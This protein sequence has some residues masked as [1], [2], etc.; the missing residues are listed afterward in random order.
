LRDDDRS[1]LPPSICVA[2]NKSGNKVYLTGV[3][4]LK[5]QPQPK[6]TPAGSPAGVLRRIQD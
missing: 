3:Y 1:G 2:F 5:T 6:K 4:S